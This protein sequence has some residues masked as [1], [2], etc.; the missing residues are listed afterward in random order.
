MTLNQIIFEHIDDK[1]AYGKYGD[2]KVIMM[3]K[4][5]YINATKL[6]KEYGKE[7]F[8]WKQSKNNQELI[9]E[10][11]IDIYSVLGIQRIENKSIIIIKG[12]NNQLICGTYVNELLIPHIASWI[13]SKF[14]VKVSKI[15][16]SFIAN[17]YINE[18][19]DK[20]NKINNLEEK[21][22]T[23]IEDNKVILK[24]NEELLKQSKKAEKNSR[25]L[26]QKLD[27]ANESLIDIKEELT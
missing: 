21:L 18:L 9:N 19:K 27:D 2:F 24:S 6:C 17:E 12:G 14:A 11:E 16:N 20:N 1:Y 25:K 3:T 26:A 10:V 22:N 5:R 23:I 4:N 8:N 7:F 13:S 15:I